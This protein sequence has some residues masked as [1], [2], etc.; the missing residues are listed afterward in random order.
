MK[1][2]AIIQARMGSTRLPG[3][4]MK[5]LCGQTV[6]GHVVSRVKECEILDG[7]IVATTTL[8]EDDVL[9]VEGRK[10][11]AFTYRGSSDNVLSRYYHA[12]CEYN[13]D[14]VVRITSDCPLFDADLLTE[15]LTV[16]LKKNSPCRTVDY[17]SN[18]LDRTYPRG[19]DAEIFYMD[20]LKKAYHQATKDYEKEHVTPY[21]Y[22]HSDEFV[23]LQ[24]K[25]NSNNFS[26]YRWTLDTV[27]DLKL[28]K[29]I[30]NSLWN[31][32]N[33]FKRDDIYNILND[34]ISWLEI[35][36]NVVQKVLGQ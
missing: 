16:F 15:M 32:D 10:F 25:D 31:V 21:I 29:L 18:T 27:E 22:Q 12:A 8:Q 28:I 24:H 33:I 17:L 23:I 35:N 30:Y 7:V 1:I 9:E 34:N 11:G 26:D 5:L 36:K 4:V 19:L 6:L 13:A 14:V 3:K 20:V 2:L